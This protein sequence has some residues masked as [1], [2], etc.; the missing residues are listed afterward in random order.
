MFYTTQWLGSRHS[1]SDL[2]PQLRTVFSSQF[3]E[4]RVFIVDCTVLNLVFLWMATKEGKKSDTRNSF[5][6]SKTQNL[7][8]YLT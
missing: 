6:S 3:S 2:D 7:F 5:E 1:R 4:F 8:I